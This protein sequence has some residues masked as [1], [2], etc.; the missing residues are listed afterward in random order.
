MTLSADTSAAR[1]LADGLGRAADA[2]GDLGPTN[3]EAGALVLSASRPPVRRGDL[4]AGMYVQANA[5]GALMASRA[6]HFTFVHWGAPRANVRANP[7]ILA[8]LR[9]RTDQVADL[10]LT[11]AR[12]A[13]ADNL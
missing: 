9:A 11:H 6:R 2:L 5:Q 8:A 12:D 1:A 3:R 4:A 13:L 7:F 10:Y